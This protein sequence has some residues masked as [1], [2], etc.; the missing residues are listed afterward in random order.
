VAELDGRFTVG[1]T[2]TY[3]TDAPL[4]IGTTPVA[5]PLD[6]VV[7]ATLAGRLLSD[8]GGTTAHRFATSGY[9]TV[10]V[11]ATDCPVAGDGLTVDVKVGGVSRVSWSGPYGHRLD[12]ETLRVGKVAAGVDVTVELSSAASH[13]VDGIQVTFEHVDVGAAVIVPSVLDL[14]ALYRWGNDDAVTQLNLPTGAAEGDL[15]VVWFSVIR[16]NVW[17]SYPTSEITHSGVSTV[18]NETADPGGGHLA[19]LL[20]GWK[21]LTAT[22]ISGGSISVS[23]GAGSIRRAHLLL[24]VY[25]GATSVGAA[26]GTYIV[27]QT[28]GTQ[29]WTLNL[30]DA[31]VALGWTEG[32]T[33]TGWTSGAPGYDIAGATEAR[34]FTQTDGAGS[35]RWTDYR[36]AVDG[37]SLEVSPFVSDLFLIGG[38]LL[39]VS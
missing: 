11:T 33:F 39:E 27:R 29:G 9:K 8:L 37:V 2:V 15:V 10:T 22:D 38:C 23:V 36:V 24:A 1:E 32:I 31:N 21:Q 12:A 26:T 14:G 13:D 25:P 5:V 30:A 17:S 3:T 35:T 18:V 4:T 20:V 19:R 28:S 16:S 34:Q 6:T 7:E